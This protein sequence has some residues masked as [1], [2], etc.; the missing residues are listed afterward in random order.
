MV[1]HVQMYI[2]L[3]SYKKYQDRVFSIST[4]SMK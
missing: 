2:V 4:W 3:V 1:L